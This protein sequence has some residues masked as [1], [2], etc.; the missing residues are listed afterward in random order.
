MNKWKRKV[1]ALARLA[2][3]QRGKP[4]GELARQKMRGIL[5][6][7]PEARDYEPIRKF[8]ASDLSYLV[9][10]HIPLTG[11]WEGGSPAEALA[12]MFA[13]Y[14]KRAD[15]HRAG[16]SKDQSPRQVTDKQRFLMRKFSPH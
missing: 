4:E 12:A 2:E 10:A 6:K 5:E 1:Q 9:K 8:V 15:E 7:Y 16:T 13:D 11:H 14:A 3:D